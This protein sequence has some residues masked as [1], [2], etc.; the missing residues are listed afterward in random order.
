[1][2]GAS[3]NMCTDKDLASQTCGTHKGVGMEKHMGKY[4]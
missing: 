2:K 1:M 4:K 3:E